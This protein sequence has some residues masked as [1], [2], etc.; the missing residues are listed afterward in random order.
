MAEIAE[1][2]SQIF[3]DLEQMLPEVVKLNLVSWITMIL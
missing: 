3:T 1:D 2:W